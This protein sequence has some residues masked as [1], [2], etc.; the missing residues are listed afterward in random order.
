MLQYVKG[1]QWRMLK[2]FEEKITYAVEKVKILKEE[3][4]SLE[5]RIGELESIIGSKD[6]EIEKLTSE[7]VNI[8]A[9]IEDLFN[10]LE[11]I[12]LK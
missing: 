9:Q 11:S 6:Q 4:S 2:T 12:E 10:E 5:K 1:G 3:K 8:K 7:R